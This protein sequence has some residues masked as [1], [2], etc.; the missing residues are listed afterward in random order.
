VFIPWRRRLG[1]VLGVEFGDDPARK[2]VAGP[3]PIAWSKDEGKI[4]ATDGLWIHGVAWCE[5]PDEPWIHGWWRLV[6]H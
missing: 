2:E 5:A 3:G 1:S 6:R 4:E